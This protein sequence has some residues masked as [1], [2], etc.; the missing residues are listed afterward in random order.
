MSMA[1]TA[2]AR[3]RL[4]W[5][6]ERV[7]KVSNST[8]KIQLRSVKAHSWV[9]RERENT[10]LPAATGQDEDEELHG[11]G[12]DD[13]GSMQRPLL[14]EKH[15]A[16]LTHSGACS[17]HAVPTV[18]VEGA[19]ERN[20]QVRAAQCHHTQPPLHAPLCVHTKW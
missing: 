11:L 16:Q 12:A 17:W 6:R 7:E 18:R 4:S 3:W 5:K 9:R 15:V 10:P 20:G 19:L 1:K 13:A 8:T 14:T 2:M